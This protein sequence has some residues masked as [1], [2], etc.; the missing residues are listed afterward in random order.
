MDPVTESFEAWGGTHIHNTFLGDDPLESDIWT[1]HIPE[2]IVF[3]GGSFKEI[4]ELK[5]ETHD[6]EK[7]VSEG[8]TEDEYYKD[9]I[10]ND[11][12]DGGAIYDIDE[13]SPYIIDDK[14]EENK[15][16]E[17]YGGSYIVDDVENETEKGSIHSVIKSLKVMLETITV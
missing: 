15:D 9:L 14:Y 12:Y 7:I 11:S 4:V 1:M 13:N 8:K 5:R 16:D 2:N 17:M 10:I 3:D 6:L